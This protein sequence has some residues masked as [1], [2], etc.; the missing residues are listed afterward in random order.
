MTRSVKWRLI[1]IGFVIAFSLFNLYP[2]LKWMSLSNS[3]K[4]DLTARWDDQAKELREDLKWNRLTPR[5]RVAEIKTIL[6]P[7]QAAYKENKLDKTFWERVNNPD[8]SSLVEDEKEDFL[9]LCEKLMGSKIPRDAAAE[10]IKEAVRP[11]QKVETALKGKDLQN[12][13]QKPQWDTLKKR[14]R[15]KYRDI[16]LQ[17]TGK[18]IARTPSVARNMGNWFTRWWQGDESQ[19]ISLGLDLKGGSYFI[20]EVEK[21][22]GVSLGDATEGAIRVL[23]DRVDR[24]GVREPVIQRQGLNKII[25]QLPG[26]TDIS[27]QRR[28]L[29]RQASMRWMLAEEKRMQDEQFSEERLLNLYQRAE[30]ELDAE[31]RNKKDDRGNPIR[32]TMTDLDTKLADSLPSDTMLRVYEHEERGPAGTRAMRR[33]PLLLRS[34]PEEPEVLK[35]DEV[36]RAQASRDPETGE[37]IILFTL[38]AKGGGRFADITREYNARSANRIPVSGSEPRG[39][40]LVILLDDRVIS[41]PN[42][43]TEI[44]GGSGQIEG[45]FAPEEARDL[46][47]QI[48]AGALPA[49]LNI[50]SQNTVGPTL[51]ADSIRRGATAAIVGLALI[52]LFMA[53]YYLLAGLIAN[54]ALALNLLIILGVLAALRATLTL[55]GIAGMV[56]T[57]GMAVDANV[58][59]LERIREEL[60]AAKKIGAA[61]DSGY[62]KAFLTILDS[63]LTTV[64]SA[65]VLYYIGTGPVRGFAVTLAIGIAVSMFTAI[66]V[67]RVIFDLMLRSKR[68]QTLHMLSIF[69]KPKLDFVRQMK[70]ASMVSIVVIVAGIIS[71]GAKWGQNFGIDFS[72][73]QSA[74][75]IFQN[76]VTSRQLEKIRRALK[77]SPEIDDF[78]LRHFRLQ[79]ETSRRGVTVDAKLKETGSELGARTAKASVGNSPSG[80]ESKPEFALDKRIA[81]ALANDNPLDEKIAPTVAEVYPTVS[82]HLWRQAI[83]AILVSLLAM[84]IYIAWRF[85]FRFAIGG[86]IALFHDVLVTVAFMT[87]FLILARRQLNLPV[88][89]ALLTII[90]YSINDTIVIFDR[91]RENMKLMKGVDLRTIINTS[92][93]QTLSRTLLTS[94]TTLLAVLSLFLFGGQAINDFSFAMLVGCI[95]GVYSTVYIASPIVLVLEKKK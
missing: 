81:E 25:V 79:G 45:N 47:I 53:V 50:V 30:D 2:S 67:T 33:D 71:F 21:P 92:V 76:E 7:L 16:I 14:D 48:K 31:F 52:V 95:A 88:I 75:L 84:L 46:A 44:L 49:K 68:F 38:N 9:S 87:G 56:L 93:N 89:A 55:P 82:R 70:K 77:A 85:E 62:Q 90:G 78:N 94:L 1:I 43:R 28:L 86:I 80:G 4:A 10:Q 6:E 20:M 22:K 27:R 3:E 26:L 5:E 40:R 17:L 23:T 32:W 36:T 8:L 34:S 18:R 59:I 69:R 74:T 51:G 39:W 72:S 73:G 19:V 41:A 61:I 37:P 12:W 35:G 15:E 66:V 64:I 57:I 58:L 29:E 54:F 63:N 42:I 65:I 83:I 13:A 11:L 24:M 60:A 91:I